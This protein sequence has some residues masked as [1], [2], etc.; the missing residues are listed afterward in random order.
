MA[1]KINH[2][3]GLEIGQC[4]LK[5]LRCH[6]EGGQVIA[7][8]FDFVEYPKI[9][10]QP[11][12]EPEMLV[13]DAMQQFVSRNDLR[14]AKVGISVPGQSGL[15]KF[16]KPP[17][18]EVK[19]IPDIVKYEAKQ[20]I[21]FD[22]NDVIWDFQQMAGS[23]IEDGY[24]LESEVGL[25]AMKKEAVYRALRPFKEANIDVD[26]IQLAPVSVYNMAAYDRFA[27]K[28]EGVVFD[29]DSPP[30]STVILS[31]GTDAS[32]LVVTNG[33]RIWQRNIPIGG[34]HFT[35]QLLKDLKLTFAKAEHLKRNVMQSDDPK[36]V[37]QVMRPVFNDLV[38]EIQRS[39]GFFRSLNKKAEIEGLI[40]LGNSAKLPGLVP[41]M[42]KNL[43]MEVKALDRYE[44]LEG[45]EVLGQPAFKENQAG[46]G[47][48]YGLCLQLLK[49]GPMQTNLL[50]REIVVD[51][52]I[53][54]KKPCAIGALSAVLLGIVA[55]YASVFGAYKNVAPEKWGD[56][57]QQVAATQSTSQNLVNV[58]NER[59]STLEFLR[60]VGLEVSSN[61]DRRLMWM[62]LLKTIHEGLKFDPEDALKTP[63]EKPYFQ[64]EEF[65]LTKIDSSYVEDLS[66]WFQP[67]QNTYAQ[68][69]LARE[70]LVKRPPK[71]AP[72]PDQ[73]PPPPPVTSPTG[74]GWVV[75]IE[76]FHYF[77]RQKGLEGADHVRKNLIDYLEFGEVELPGAN[78]EMTKF[79][80]KELGVSFPLMPKSGVLDP[81]HLVPNPDFQ[82]LA[83]AAVGSSGDGESGDFGGGG[84]EASQP[85][86]IT[87]VKDA[88]G[89]DVPS[90]FEAPKYRFV[91][92]FAWQ[93]KT[94]AE[95]LRWRQDPNYDK[96]TIPPVV[97]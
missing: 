3:W 24:A 97:K 39:I 70:T 73:P 36:L 69:N 43:G 28:M 17:P 49:Q 68:E 60:R 48:V 6:V 50:P 35:R 25:F 31:M 29:P 53:R 67:L 81:K 40:L 15:A 78:G 62:E 13:A 88:N 58:D 72:A 85:G 52:L 66:R 21:P 42:N 94:F 12:A 77:N 4:A 34:N 45:T 95:R 37:F 5:A 83:G 84:F 75:Q 20:Q 1:K 8:M 92:Q 90:A 27:E 44:R 16:F 30:P 23:N 71:P 54:S 79:T 64:R 89:K 57:E 86:K 87:I 56:A 76:G 46:F 26:L 33:F 47:V 19:K 14:G 63:A 59:K 10:S 93:E 11:E 82:R 65:H 9:L 51:R 74:P 7:D 41:Y 22:L 38:T 80:L 32:D 55:N 18:V 91:V 61:G 96:F 2:A